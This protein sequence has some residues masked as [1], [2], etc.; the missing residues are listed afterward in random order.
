VEDKEEI[1]AR[2][3]PYLSELCQA[4][5]VPLVDLVR[6]MDTFDDRDLSD[7]PLLTLGSTLQGGRNNVISPN[8]T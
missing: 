5:I 3:L 6:A 8:C 1:P 2:L 4:L 7:L